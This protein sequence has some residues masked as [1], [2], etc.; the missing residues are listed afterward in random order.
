MYHSYSNDSRRQR[1]RERERDRREKKKWTAESSVRVLIRY[2]RVRLREHVKSNWKFCVR[3]MVRQGVRTAQ[4]NQTNVR[5]QE[6][7][8]TSLNGF[9]YRHTSTY[10]N[11][12]YM[13]CYAGC[14]ESIPCVTSPHNPSKYFVMVELNAAA[15]DS[16]CDC[17]FHYFYWLW[18]WI[19]KN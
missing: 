6:N 19:E 4:S 17:R 14:F 11:D 15:C 12:T 7:K 1:A 18:I 9:V 10:D 3:Q 8:T 5:N 13:F 2:I 16:T